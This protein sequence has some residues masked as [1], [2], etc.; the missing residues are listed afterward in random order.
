MIMYNFFPQFF[1]FF[2]WLFFFI[3]LLTFPVFSQLTKSHSKTKIITLSEIKPR[4]ILMA[5]TRID[6]NVMH[7]FPVK[8][9]SILRMPFTSYP[10]ILAESDDPFILKTKIAAGMS[11]SPVY[12]GDRL[13]GAIAYSWSFLEKPIMGITPI[14]EMLPI[15]DYQGKESHDSYGIGDGWNESRHSPNSHNLDKWI[16]SP[17]I[18]KQATPEYY[19]YLLSY[20]SLSQKA[21]SLQKLIESRS[22][23]P[24]GSLN[25][26]SKSKIFK[27]HKH[28]ENI[29]QT[30]EKSSLPILVSWSTP[31]IHGIN[32][33]IP[34]GWELLQKNL[35]SGMGLNPTFMP[36]P[37]QGVGSG[38]LENELSLNQ[39]NLDKLIP[40]D[41]IGVNLIRGAVEINIFGTVTYVQGDTILAF[42]HDM[43]KQGAVRLPLYHA[44]TEMVLP[45]QTASF[46]MGSLVKEI[47]TIEQDRQPGILGK[48]GGRAS[49][50]P[51]ELVLDTPLHKDTYR[52]EVVNDKQISSSLVNYGISQ[53]YSWMENDSQPVSL[54]Y[55]IRLDFI[56]YSDHSLPS[57][58]SNQ[59]GVPRSITFFDHNSS[60]N[61]RNGINWI[62]ANLSEVIDMIHHNSW[63]VGIVTNIKVNIIAHSGY[64]YMQ[65]AAIRIPRKIYRPGEMIR[66][67]VGF[68]RYQKPR[69]YR[70]FHYSIPIDTPDGNHNLA[71]SSAQLRWLTQ[72]FMSP[73]S[74]KTFEGI[75]KF[76]ESRP[77]SSQLSIWNLEEAGLKIKDNVY[78]QLPVIQKKLLLRSLHNEKGS[79]ANVKYYDYDLEESVDGFLTFNYQVDSNYKD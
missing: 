78:Q 13:V 70:D 40:G 7:H 32:Q 28:N 34:F 8:V 21:R 52:F 69:I 53:I 2:Y 54:D 11:G 64:K 55:S 26:E 14:E 30:L 51:V 65:A 79:V 71:I 27:F 35:F 15:I 66:F 67:Q 37:L 3:S 59:S 42:G 47:G 20:P 68:D 46:K 57:I 1:L 48:I 18:L 56:D 31:G 45:I 50:L 74:L 10:I 60:L 33:K 76:I 6:G 41:Y 44:R 43:G 61:T 49:Y 39:G 9:L 77:S 5:K 17:Q 4:D 62:V 12:S 72:N 19:E 75:S 22:D 36:M 63:E 25:Q 16:Y 58:T 29:S 38:I 73:Y 23:L 24:F